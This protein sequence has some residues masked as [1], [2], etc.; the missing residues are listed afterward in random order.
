MPRPSNEVEQLALI[1]QPQPIRV[2]ERLWRSWLEDPTVVA[3][4]EAKRYIRPGNLCTPWLAGVSSTGHGTFRAASLPGPSRRGTVPA[5]LFAYQLEYGVIPRL[6]W[7]GSDD[8]VL[9]HQ[10]DF[11]GCVNPSHMRLGT[12]ATNRR[13]YTQRRRN[14]SSPL[15]DIRGPAGRTRAI[16]NSIRMGIS[17]RETAAAIESRI[18][19][20]EEAGLPLTLW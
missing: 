18:Q 20:A 11:A 5:H 14:I 3:R 10:C 6:G 8:A 15:S 2:P 16:A 19:A 13:E 7:S 12:N 17:N 4:F 1:G 9:C